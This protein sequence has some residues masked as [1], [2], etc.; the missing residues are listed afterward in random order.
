MG[1][2]LWNGAFSCP[3]YVL[4]FHGRPFNFIATRETPNFRLQQTHTHGVLLSRDT[5]I[6][7]TN[8]IIMQLQ[9]VKPKMD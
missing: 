5:R 3:T 1:C 8:P 4:L 9:N 6:Y 7:G 2:G